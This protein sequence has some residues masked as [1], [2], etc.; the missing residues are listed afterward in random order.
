SFAIAH[1]NLAIVYFEKKK[2]N[3]AIKHVDKAVELGYEVD[4][5]L[6]KEIETFR[7]EFG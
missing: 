7:K 6:L 4:P 3:L 2:Y 5:E 1:N